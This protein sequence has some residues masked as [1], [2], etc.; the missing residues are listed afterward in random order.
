M[1]DRAGEVPQAP[2]CGSGT[3]Q[4]ST[5]PLPGRS[6]A[7]STWQNLSLRK[8]RGETVVSSGL[9]IPWALGKSQTQMVVEVRVL[10]NQFQII[11]FQNSPKHL[12]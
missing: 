11:K 9:P 7:T 12:N 2:V 8:E 6:P 10:Y 1:E 3:R 5:E 4:S